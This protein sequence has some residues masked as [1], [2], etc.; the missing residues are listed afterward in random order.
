MIINL[1]L[2]RILL[3]GYIFLIHVRVSTNST[4]INIIVLWLLL[5]FKTIIDYP[6]IEF[7]NLQLT[8]IKCEYFNI[9]NTFLKFLWI[10]WF[11]FFTSILRINI[12]I[13]YLLFLVDILFIILICVVSQLTSMDMKNIIVLISVKNFFW[14]YSKWKINR[15]YLS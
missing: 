2:E 14:F 10:F 3:L 13:F 1:T 7:G 6:L 12:D 5:S 9:L 15:I 8:F 4:L 11:T